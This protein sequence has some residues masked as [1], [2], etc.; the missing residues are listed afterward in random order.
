MGYHPVGGYFTVTFG[1]DVYDTSGGG[2][3]NAGPPNVLKDGDVSTGEYQHGR[4][5]HQ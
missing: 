1:Q 3:A 2:I 4:E 5:R